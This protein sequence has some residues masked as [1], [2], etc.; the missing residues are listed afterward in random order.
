MPKNFDSKKSAKKNLMQT[1]MP[2]LPFAKQMKLEEEAREREKKI[3]SI[4][5]KEGRFTIEEAQ[6]LLADMKSKQE[7]IKHRLDELYEQRGVTPQ[8]LKSYMSNSLNFT[9]E[10]WKNLNTQRQALID[11]LDLP[12]ELQEKIRDS[13]VPPDL[14]PV[15]ERRSKIAKVRRRNW[16]PMR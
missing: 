10:Q 12:L 15:K 2:P 8:Y 13:N 6:I 5:K 1:P 16:L 14:Q 11:S 3:K 7:A 9:P 4:M